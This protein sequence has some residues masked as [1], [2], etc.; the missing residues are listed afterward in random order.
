V[1]LKTLSRLSTATLYLW[2]FVLVAVIALLRRHRLKRH[3][4]FWV[5]GYLVCAGV[6]SLVRSVG[7]TVSWTHYIGVVPQDQI[8]VALVNA[9][10]SV[11]SLAAIVSIAP[12]LWLSRACSQ[13]SSAE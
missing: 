10:L 1:D 4:A 9:S 12:V 7:Y 6:Q 11:I 2:P 13:E 5:L 8:L 3:L